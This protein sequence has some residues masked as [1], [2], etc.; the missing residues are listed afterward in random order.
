VHVPRRPEDI[1]GQVNQ[2]LDGVGSLCGIGQVAD[3]EVATKLLGSEM[4]GHKRLFL[5][6]RVG[7]GG[8]PSTQAIADGR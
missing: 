2:E 7:K 8:F 1:N 5:R 6:V 4:D 3:L